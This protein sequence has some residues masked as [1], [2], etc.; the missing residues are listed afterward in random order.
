MRKC[1]ECGAI[2]KPQVY[3]TGL[4]DCCNCQ[5]DIQCDFDKTK[6]VKVTSYREFGIEC[7]KNGTRV[8]EDCFACSHL[9]LMCK[10]YGGQCISS[11][12]RQERIDG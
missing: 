5:V 12:C 3:E 11:K 7:S 1:K 6:W 2:V 10:K 9:L 8:E 4:V